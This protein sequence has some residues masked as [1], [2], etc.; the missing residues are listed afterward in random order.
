[1]LDIHTPTKKHTPHLPIGQR[2]ALTFDTPNL[3]LGD[4][5]VSTIDGRSLQIRRLEARRHFQECVRASWS[6]N[7]AC[8]GADGMYARR[9]YA[10]S[11]PRTIW[12]RR[13]D[14][15]RR[16]HALPATNTTRRFG[17]KHLAR[18]HSE[19]EASASDARSGMD[20]R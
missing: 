17:N 12:A 15:F 16:A 3:N 2:P 5:R 8:G 18:S 20:F 7:M 19:S 1:M 10:K 11:C 4:T 6:V 14:L 13:V 9:L